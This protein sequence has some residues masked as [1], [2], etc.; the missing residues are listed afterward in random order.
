[1]EMDMKM[2]MM[3]FEE[4]IEYSDEMK[5]DDF[6]FILVDKNYKMN[7]GCII[8]NKNKN[9]VFK[10]VR[11][12]INFGI[13]ELVFENCKDV[14]GLKKLDIEERILSNKRLIRKSK[15]GIWIKDM[16]LKCEKKGVMYLKMLNFENIGS[17]VDN[18]EFCKRIDIRREIL[19]ILLIR[20]LFDI[21]DSNR[22]N[23]LIN[24]K[25]EVL[26]IDNNKICDNNRKNFL[27]DLRWE[28]YSNGDFEN[29]LDDIFSN[30]EEKENII[31]DVFKEYEFDD[32]IDKVLEN[33]N[34]L[35]KNFI[36]EY[37]KKFK[38]VKSVKEEKKEEKK[39]EI[40]NNMKVL[41]FGSISY[42]NY[43]IDI[44][45]SGLNKY[46]RRNEFEKG[47]YC[48]IEMDLFKLLGDKGKGIRSNMINRL[49]IVLNEDIGYNLG[50][51]NYLK[52]YKLL[53]KWKLYR[54][55]YDDDK[56]R[57]YLINIFRIMFLRRGNR[58]CSWIR[59][60]YKNGIENDYIKEKYSFLYDGIEDIE[61]EIGRRFYMKNDDEE[62]K[63]YIDG[64]VKFLN[65]K[66][67]KVYFFLFKILNFEGVNG[68]R[69]RKSKKMFIILDILKRKCI[70]NDNSKK[71]YDFIEE[72][73]VNFNNIRNEFW[74]SIVNFIRFY[75]NDFNDNKNDDDFELWNLEY[76][77][78]LYDKNLKGL[79]LKMDDY[80]M[81]KHVFDKKIKDKKLLNEKFVFE[82]SF[83]ENEVINDDE[84]VY[85]EIYN[86]L[87]LI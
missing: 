35:K 20:E 25:G 72:L 33:F 40:K 2:K 48:L 65:E 75:F 22:R 27:K 50:I 5:S 6:D 85:K 73:C 86:Y 60:V 52:I 62:L 18:K 28:D 21:G 58:I 10:E 80:L 17:C 49:M 29:V 63:R 87:S 64:F 8:Y 77:N 78:N 9:Y 30:K 79:K 59:K 61:N 74:I 42:N 4:M 24:N 39:E 71:L 57:F 23:I 37:K 36:I 76:I 14:F 47:L 81:D 66:N 68:K 12:C 19:K 1:M 34:N 56:D 7:K 41:S 51:S 11:K 38:K 83:V 44:L 16:D 54:N 70:R 69:G 55:C 84:I 45:K 31:I 3:N 15:K 46:V 53:M 82:G 13:D 32:K 26:S 67:D 43:K